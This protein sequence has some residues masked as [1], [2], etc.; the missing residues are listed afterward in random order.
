MDMKQEMRLI[1]DYVD[2]ERAYT[3]VKEIANFHR[4]QASTGFRAAAEHVCGVLKKEGFDSTIRS[5]PFDEKKWY[6]TCKSFLEWD[7]KDAWCDLVVPEQRRLTDFRANNIAVI[8]KSF[9]CD[10]SDTPLDV[11]M[12]DQGPDESHYEGL[13]LKGKIIFVHDAFNPYMGWALQKRGA[14]GI[15]TDFMREVPGVRDRYD[16]FD[17]K[18]YTSFWCRDT[19]KEPHA[20]GFVLTPREGDQLAALCRKMAAEHAADPSKPQYP[21]VT[22]K[23]DSSLYPGAVEVVDTFLPGETDE[24]ILVVAHLCHPRASANDNAS[25][26]AAGMEMLRPLKELTEGG[27]LPPSSA[28]SGSSSSPNSPAPTP[29][30]RAGSRN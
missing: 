5:Y 7:C 8:Q 6:W 23:V 19:T 1:R 20:F 9:P 2:G 10:Y 18:N 13:D 28:A 12:L 11:V 29:I 3:G 21:Q 4:I 15:I 30:W 26:V 17:I 16:L 22:C 24:E 27:K 25:G 14:V